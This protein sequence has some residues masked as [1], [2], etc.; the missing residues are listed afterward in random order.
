MRLSRARHSSCRHRAS[1]KI[2]SPSSRDSP[3]VLMSTRQIA[4]SSL[5]EI[6]SALSFHSHIPWYS[7]CP[8]SPGL[9]ATFSVPPKPRPLHLYALF[10]WLGAVELGIHLSRC[11]P[12]FSTSA[13]PLSTDDSRQQFPFLDTR[14]S[15]GLLVMSLNNI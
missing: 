13:G 8:G 12:V 15:L 14:L 3:S 2:F 1:V 11:S 6:H 10:R 5:T 9:P 7:H 4:F